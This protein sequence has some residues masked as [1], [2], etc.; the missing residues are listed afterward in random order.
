VVSPKIL[1]QVGVGSI[2]RSALFF[3]RAESSAGQT[4]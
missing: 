4:Q 3:A 2:A 1:E